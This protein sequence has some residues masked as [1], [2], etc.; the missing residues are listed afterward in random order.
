MG[1]HE[2]NSPSLAAARPAMPDGTA[3][4]R[5]KSVLFVVNT[6]GRAGAERV[7]CTLFSLFDHSNLDIH[8]LSL[9]PRGEM[10]AEVPQT[11]EILNKKYK[12]RSVLSIGGRIAGIIIVLKSL[13]KD[14]Y[15]IKNR[16]Y[17]MENY[18]QQ[19]THLKKL[20]LDKLF[21]HAISE[22]APRLSKKYDLAVAFLEGGSC[23]YVAEHVNAAKKAAFVHVDYEMSG[24][25]PA[26]DEPYFIKMDKIFCVS[27]WVRGSFTRQFPQLAHRTFLLRN[28]VLSDMVLERA[29]LGEGFDDG[30]IGIRLLT[31]ARLHPQKAYDIAIKAMQMLVMEGVTNVRWYAMGEGALRPSLQGLIDQYG[32]EDYFKLMGARS[33]PYPYLKQ[34]DIYVHATHF[35]G[36]SIAVGEALV[37]KKLIIASNCAGNTEQ[38]ENEKT[39]IIIDLS[40]R[41]LANA[42]QRMINDKELRER[43]ETNLSSHNADNSADINMLFDML[44]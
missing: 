10:F 22:A 7:L 4:D 2:E 43:L 25:S 16:K 36:M 39:G 32:I 3:H 35:E 41:E 30:F 38:I 40:A 29:E 23:Y 9:I 27:N 21:W 17:L 18:R 44:N 14:R 13:F 12:K 34:C 11:V 26:L 19:H 33:N 1:L 6:M 24:Y 20:Q 42:I 5:K 15:I 8:L 28:S 37:L 31:I